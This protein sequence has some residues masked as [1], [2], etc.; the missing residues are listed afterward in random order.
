MFSKAFGQALSEMEFKTAEQALA[1]VRKEA[2]KRALFGAARIVIPAATP[3]LATMDV[4]AP[5][6][7]VQQ[8]PS[9]LN[10]LQAGIRLN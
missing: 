7:T 5:E 3:M 2:T 6:R 8:D 1:N 9:I 4:E 10:K